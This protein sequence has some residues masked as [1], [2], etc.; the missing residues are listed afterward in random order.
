MDRTTKAHFAKIKKVH[1]EN[2]KNTRKK[3]KEFIDNET[4]HIIKL[5]GIEK[6]TANSKIDEI[7]K[8]VQADPM[9]NLS[10]ESQFE[11]AYDTFKKNVRSVCGTSQIDELPLFAPNT[12]IDDEFRPNTAIDEIPLFAPNTAIDEIPLFAP[13]TAIDDEIIAPNIE[14]DF[15]LNALTTPRNDDMD[16]EEKKELFDEIS[17]L[18]DE[19]F[20]GVQQIILASLPPHMQT[21]EQI[22]IDFGTLDDATLRRLQDYVF[23]NSHRSPSPKK[24]KSPTPK[25]SPTRRKSP[26]PKKS[27]TRRKSSVPAQNSPIRIAREE[28]RKQREEMLNKYKQQEED[29]EDDFDYDLA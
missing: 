9:N 4:K 2:M 19:K 28:A 17:K 6:D 15:D 10:Y 16:S 27:P 26:S 29:D 12:A 24:R 5:I 23:D 1:L 11:N 18:S 21:G 7:L 13:N 25:K 8:K 14:F 20:D 22:E 3:Y